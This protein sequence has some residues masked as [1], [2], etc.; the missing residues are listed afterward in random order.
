MVIDISQVRIILFK[1]FMPS[2]EGAIKFSRNRD[3]I[4]ETS[5]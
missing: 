1:R 4:E 5:S 3:T 2:D